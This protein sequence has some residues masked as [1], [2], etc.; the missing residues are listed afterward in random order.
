M[1]HTTSPASARPTPAT[2]AG[3]GVTDG[4]Q[5]AGSVLEQRWWRLME[6]RIGI[7]PLPVYVVLLGVIAYFIATKKIS[8][9][10]NM[11]IAVLAVFGFTCAELGNRLPFIR[12]IGGAAIFATFLPSCLAYY[13]LIPPTL[14][15]AVTQFTKST[16]FLYLFISAIIVGS[17]FGIDRSV[18]MRGFVKIFI[19]LATG[20]VAA[21]LV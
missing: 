13:Q 5:R 9:E 17:V 15:T 4:K 18:L 12:N 19:P 8:T 20:T 6:T 1:D 3:K 14:V 11:M 10:I 16:N 7:I 2:S 21:L